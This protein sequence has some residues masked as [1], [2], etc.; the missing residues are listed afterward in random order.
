VQVQDNARLEGRTI[1][2][3]V[4]LITSYQAGLASNRIY[5]IAEGLAMYDTHLEVPV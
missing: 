5:T 2:D 4:S 1:L 3:A